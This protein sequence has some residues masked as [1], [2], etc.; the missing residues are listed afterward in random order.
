MSLKEL[1]VSEELNSLSN[2]TSASLSFKQL[3]ISMEALKISKEFVNTAK[4]NNNVPILK[5][6]LEELKELKE[7][8]N[9]N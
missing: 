3:A 8:K 9:G 2:I 4:N 6:I 7:L 1:I 5:E